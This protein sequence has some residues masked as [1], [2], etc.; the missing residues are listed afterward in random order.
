MNFRIRWCAMKDVFHN[1]STA[2]TSPIAQGCNFLMFPEV[3]SSRSL[4]RPVEF[5]SIADRCERHK[6]VAFE[7][8]LSEYLIKCGSIHWKIIM[9]R[10]REFQNRCK[11]KQIKAPYQSPSL[12]Y[13]FR[14]VSYIFSYFR[15]NSTCCTSTE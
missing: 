10:L 8:R 11:V 5:K 3:V 7:R 12:S 4:Y 14:L 15:L 13:D 2:V 6:F 9:S 1:A